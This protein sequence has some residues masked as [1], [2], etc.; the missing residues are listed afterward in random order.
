MKLRVTQLIV[1]FITTLLTLGCSPS[2]VEQ[3]TASFDSNRGTIT[4]TLENMASCNYRIKINE[5]EIDSGFINQT[6]ELNILDLIRNN[7]GITKD[8]AMLAAKNSNNINI[9]FTL[10][11][12]LDTVYN[13][14]IT[15]S[16]TTPEYDIQ[17]T[18]IGAGVLPKHANRN[19]DEELKRWLYRKREVVNDSLYLALRTNYLYLSEENGNNFVTQGEIPVIHSLAGNTY[20]INCNMNADYYAV[21][22]CR[23]QKSIDDFIENSVARDFQN[24][25]LTKTNVPCVGQIQESGY[26][27][28]VLLGINRDYSYHQIPFAIV[29]IDNSAPSNKEYPEQPVSFNFKNETRILIPSNAPE[30][31]GAAAVEVAHWSGTTLECN[32]TFLV[33]FVGDAKSVTIHRRGELC[34]PQPYLGNYFPVANKVFYAKDGSKQRF[35]WKMHFNDGDNE[36]PITVEDNHGNK[37]EYNIVVRAEFVS[38]DAPQVNI[39]NNIDIYN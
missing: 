24:L 28:L 32:V 3:A 35:I 1:G 14:H 38:S 36:I 27:C 21:V 34:Y 18:G 19:V 16:L 30:I 26:S 33:S 13:Y 23:D 37:K 39:D 25:S 10:N 31:F 5:Y 7:S 15:P 9:S 6:F 20:S 29:A 8:I 22:S 11:D 12:I 2:A 17:F 4:G